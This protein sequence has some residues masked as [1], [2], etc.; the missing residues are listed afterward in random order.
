MKL[1]KGI[2][3]FA[4]ILVLFTIVS[5]FAEVHATTAT[6][7]ITLS[8]KPLRNS[9]QGYKVVNNGEKYIWKIYNT[10]NNLNEHF[11]VLKVDQDLDQLKWDKILYQQIIQNIL[12]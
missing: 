3:L 4:L 2:L 7:P 9:G 12:I 5:C 1:K 11:T 10:N 6:T 8:I